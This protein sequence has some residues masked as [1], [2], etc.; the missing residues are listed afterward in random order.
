MFPVM[1]FPEVFF[2][3][4]DDVKLVMSLVAVLLQLGLSLLI[5][6]VNIFLQTGLIVITLKVV[7]QQPATISD[8]FSGKRFW[9]RMLI[10]SL[11]YYLFVIIGSFCCLVPG[12]MLA[13]IF[14][15]FGCVLIDEDRPGFDS[16]WRAKE[17]TDGNWGSMFLVLIVGLACQM[18]GTLAC[19]VGMIV[20]IPYINVLYVLAYERMTWQTSIK[21][22]LDREDFF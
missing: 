5:F 16:L 17:L 2:H 18:A 12:F 4:N 10:N 19:H 14:L 22:M 1:V 7:R 11:V 15:P 21:S 6:A 13:A 20:A 3:G 8:L 9:V